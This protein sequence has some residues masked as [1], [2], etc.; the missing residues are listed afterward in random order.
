MHGG[1]QMMFPP[2]RQQHM[3]GPPMFYQSSQPPQQHMH[4]GP[5][6][7]HGQNQHHMPPHMQ[8]Q[9]HQGMYPS[10]P[11][12]LAPSPIDMGQGMQTPTGLAPPAT[13]NG[14]NGHHGHMQGLPPPND[15]YVD[16]YGQPHGMT[17]ASAPAPYSAE[18]PPPKRQRVD[19]GE[20]P[21]EGALES[22]QETGDEDDDDEVRDRPP[23][24]A[25]FRLSNKPFKPR[26]SSQSHRRRQQLLALFQTDTVDVRAAFDL[27]PSDRPDWDV[28]MVIDEQGHTALHWACALAKMEII[29]QLI[30]L[31]ADIHRGNYS[32]ETPLIRSVLTTNHAETGTFSQLLEQ[33]LGPSVRTLDHSYSSVIHHIAQSAGLKG[34]AA[35]ARGYMAAV[36]EWIAKEATKEKLAATPTASAPSPAPQSTE[37]I[38]LKRIVD[39]QDIRGDT[40]LNVAARVGSKPL[41]NLLLDAGADKARANRLG[42]RPCDF[43]VEVDALAVST[44]DGTI[45]ALKSEIKRPEKRSADVLKS[46]HKLASPLTQ[47]ISTLFEDI[48][49][50]FDAEMEKHVE[51]LGAVEKNVR[52]A[53]RSLAERRQQVEA[54]RQRIS[55]LEQHAERAD[56]ARRALDAQEL[57]WSG[58]TPLRTETAL[59]PAFGMVPP[60][61]PSDS[62]DATDVQEASLPAQGDTDALLELRRLSAWE[63]RVVQLL[64][65]RAA[66]LEGGGADRAVK[67]RKVIALCAKVSVDKVDDV[68]GHRVRAT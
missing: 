57:E 52:V 41:V 1:P 62:A 34:R 3:Q 56:N 25:S 49:R 14:H 18:E 59:P 19:N 44:K 7:M 61:A 9:M 15:V 53:T 8:Q 38:S 35:C 29:A 12:H 24:P 33:H 55:N 51:A 64:E 50:T 65:E 58:R 45:A 36:L 2:Q 47:D 26:L 31:G 11:Q 28:D 13:I 63:D 10:G 43:G 68:S 23:L 32:G 22:I 39:L 27:G 20:A 21:K 4:Q 60:S 37:G 46:K 54:A 16:A 66:E 42:L 48:N 67:Y 40:A 6:P 5:P 30:E 17:G